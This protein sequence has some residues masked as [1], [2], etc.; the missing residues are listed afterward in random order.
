VGLSWVLPFTWELVEICRVLPS[1]PVAVIVTEAA[2]VVCQ[3]NVTAWPDA[4]LL[5]LT[6]KTSVGADAACV[7]VEL[8]AEPQ[9]V[10]AISGAIAANTSR[11]LEHVASAPILPRLFKKESSKAD[12]PTTIVPRRFPMPISFS[13]ANIKLAGLAA[14]IKL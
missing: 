8:E 5:L 11:V 10:K 3:V 2:L 4:T 1:A 7:L 9:P 6:E 14:Q 12:I 13:Q